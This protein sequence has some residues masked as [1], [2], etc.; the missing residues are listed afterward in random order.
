MAP[1]GKWH[2]EALEVSVTGENKGRQKRPCGDIELKELN[3]AG[4]IQTVSRQTNCIRG[5]ISITNATWWTGAGL[6]TTWGN[7]HCL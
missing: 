4:G 2:W 5:R 6:V 1:G 7:G 3:K